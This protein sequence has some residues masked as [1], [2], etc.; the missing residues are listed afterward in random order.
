MAGNV[1]GYDVFQT[2]VPG[3][4][5]PGERGD[6]ASRGRVD[7]DAHV[8]AVL[9]VDLADNL[10]HALDVLVLTCPQEETLSPKP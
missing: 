9:C 4:L 3:Q 1:D 7:V 8:P 6:E 2:E 5:W 10:V